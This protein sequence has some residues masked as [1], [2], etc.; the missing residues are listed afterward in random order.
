[1][2]CVLLKWVLL[3][4][5]T[6]AGSAAQAPRTV[7]T[8]IG[9]WGR[10][11]WSWF[12][13]PR[14]IHV[15]S[16]RDET[17]AGWIGWNGSI[18]VGSDDALTGATATHTVGHLFHDDHGSPALQVEPDKRLTVFWSGHNGRAMHYRTT[19]RPEDISAWGPV[20]EV[21]ARLP[22]SLGFTYPN[23]VMVAGRLY[24]FWRGADWSADYATRSP[25]GGWGPARRVIASPHQ[26]PYV[27][28]AEDGTGGIALAFTDGH[29]RELA[30]SIYYA[31]VSD[32][33]VRHASGR[34]IARLGT[35]P[36]RPAQGDR[37]YD[38]A[39]THVSSWVWD[40]AVDRG[41][42][43]VVVYATFP[44]VRTHAYWYARW[45]G[46][47][48]VSHFMTFAGPT[49][50]PR[51]IETEYSG[52]ITLDHAEPSIVYL[53]KRVHGWFE[54]ERWV[55]NDG[56]YRWRHM[57]VVRT[58]GADDVRPVVP[59]GPSG[60]LRLVWLRGHY[61]SYASYRTS[62]AYLR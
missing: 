45:D 8:P 37:V 2:W 16:P 42:H 49:I 1:M 50:S 53:S 34:P 51:T 22:G 44:S 11:A 26:R 10:G 9:S 27:K 55:T 18:E 7:A 25:A 30:T 29:P 4:L 40:V 14:A 58:P 33:W 13:D 6:A 17:F 21:P 36:I 3:A 52:G 15:D 47:R 43:P 59:R 31:A 61:G 23:P 62:V 56:G 19:L 57:T 41:G 46:R 32:G 54:L 5:M 12:A 38:A 28:V 60:S 48:W 35:G 39:R 20:G 24:L